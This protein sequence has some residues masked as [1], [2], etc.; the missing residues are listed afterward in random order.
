[1]RKCYAIQAFYLLIAA[2]NVSANTVSVGDVN[3]NGIY[4]I[5]NGNELE[6]EYYLCKRKVAGEFIGESE[7]RYFYKL[8]ISYGNKTINGNNARFVDKTIEWEITSGYIFTHG[9]YDRDKSEAY[10][11]TNNG[12]E[13]EKLC[14]ISTT[15][16][17][18]CKKCKFIPKGEYVDN[19]TMDCSNLFGKFD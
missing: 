9:I 2:T 6:R 14:I 15:N 17:F 8:D 1:M 16:Q 7:S 10:I 19:Y 3:S 5:M 12:N 11:C 13:P 18:Y 4:T